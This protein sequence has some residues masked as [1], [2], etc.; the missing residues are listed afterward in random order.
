MARNNQGNRGRGG[1]GNGNSRGGGGNRGGR[2]NNPSGNNQY[3]GS[4]VTDLVRDRPIA[5]AAVAA[6]AAA[7]GLFLWS[8]RSQISEQL[9]SLSDQ[10]G[11]WTE[12]MRSGDSAI[13]WSEDDDTSGLTTASGMSETGGGNAS[14]G[15][16]SGGAGISSTASGRGRAK[17]APT[18]G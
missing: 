6:G 10:I 11:E 9:S 17:Q 12:N 5:A 14:L 15:S 2:N 18:V 7:A 13:G 4:G 8:K 1:N 3:S 16:S